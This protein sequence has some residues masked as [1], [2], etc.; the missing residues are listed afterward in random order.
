MELEILRAIQSIH[1]PFLDAFFEGITMLG[2]EIFIVPL[3]AVIFW[4]L[5]KKFGEVLAFT[6]FTSLLFNNSLK[7]LF[8]LERP[9]GQEGIRTIRPETATGK[10]FP[11]GHSQNAGATAGAFAINMKNRAVTIIA[12]T[13]M[14]LIGLSRLYLGVHY[15]KDAIVGIL[16]GLLVAYAVSKLIRKFEP[17]KLYLIVLVLFIPALFF[18]DSG[19]F[20]KAL[21][22]YIGFVLGIYMEKKLVNFSTEGTLLRKVLRVLLG[23]ILI[24]FIKVGLEK[25][26]LDTLIFDFIRYFMI[27]FVAIGLYPWI[28]KKIRL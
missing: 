5:D 24:L 11:S 15:P 9:I 27:T 25:I 14:V 12:M 6:L 18:A 4:T 23:V 1:T 8:F 16:L 22:S 2:E 13:L 17:M 10:S 26:F 20:I 3:L 19:D 7:D 28:F 21:A